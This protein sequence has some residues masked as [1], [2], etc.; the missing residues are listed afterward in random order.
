[1]FCEYIISSKGEKVAM[2]KAGELKEQ[3]IAYIDS[4]NEWD[5]KEKETWS[6]I[7]SALTDYQDNVLQHI[8]APSSVP[9]KKSMTVHWGITSRKQNSPE[10]NFYFATAADDIHDSSFPNGN[11][12]PDDNRKMDGN[13]F[14]C[15]TG[16]LDCS[17]ADVLKLCGR[18]KC[19]KGKTENGEFE[20]CV[21]LKSNALHKEKLLYDIIRYYKLDES[22]P[23]APVLRRLVYIETKKE[24][25]K[26]LSTQDL[27][28][29]Q[30]GLESLLLN[31]RAIWNVEEMPGSPARIKNHQHYRY[32]V[33]S[34]EYIF[35]VDRSNNKFEISCEY[36]S[37]N[38][39][40]SVC[41]SSSE[42]EIPKEAFEKIHI[43]HVQLEKDI[44]S[45][46]MKIYFTPSY[47][48]EHLER[49]YSQSDIFHFLDAYRNFLKCSNIF[50]E[51][52]E[53]FMVCSYELG[54]EYPLGADYLCF[55]ERPT[56][57]VS[58]E[59]SDDMY[60]FDRVVYITYI[61][62]KQFPEYIWKGGYFV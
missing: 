32:P 55:S 8:A 52:P 46:D 22:V 35:P 2:Y 15:G 54:Y 25:Q 53:N 6:K 4:T 3:L 43:P 14:I 19:Y 17:Y 23:Y 48:Q 11:I 36:D 30:N 58:F 41:V 24:F 29:A 51:Y 38:Q 13:W 40:E 60:F 9:A 56:I 59:K 57:Y 18:D 44:F 7:I 49:I 39:K 37:E 21:V 42:R 27:Q 47:V 33:K 5:H 10:K 34:D 45:N 61:L 50:T 31:W 62:Q 26:P 16:Y 28:L 20:Y 12:F 1:M